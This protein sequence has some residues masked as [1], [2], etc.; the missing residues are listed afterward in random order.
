MRPN[1]PPF[2]RLAALIGVARKDFLDELEQWPDEPYGHCRA[3]PKK[4]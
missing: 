4:L 1:T 2:D 3:G